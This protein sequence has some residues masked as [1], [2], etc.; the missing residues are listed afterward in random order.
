MAGQYDLNDVKLLNLPKF[1]EDN[2][3]YKVNDPNNSAY[4]DSFFTYL[5]SQLYTRLNFFHGLD[6]YGSYLGY[7]NNL[8]IYLLKC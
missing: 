7:K 2:C 4:V 3:H 5:T 8:H 6:F 1:N